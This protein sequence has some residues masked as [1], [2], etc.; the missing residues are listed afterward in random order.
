METRDVDNGF[1]PALHANHATFSM[2]TTISVLENSL[3]GSLEQWTE[4]PKNGLL[5]PDTVFQVLRRFVFEQEDAEGLLA[6][7]IQKGRELIQVRQYVGLLP[8][9][10]QTQLEILPKIGPIDQARARLLTMLR[11]LRHSP[12]RTLPDAQTQAI[13][14]PLWEVFMATFL[15]TVEP[16]VRQGIQHAYVLE[17]SNERYWKGKF[18]ATRQQRE[19]AW[20][21][22]RL[23][24]IHD[25]LTADVAANRILKTLLNYLAGETK[26]PGTLRRISQLVW[27]MDEVPISDV[28]ADDFR[29]IRR[30]GRLFRRYETALHW[31][32]AL[33]YGRGYGVKTG[34]TPNL[35]LL[36][37]MERVF[38]D[39]VTHGVRTYWPESDEVRIQ[40]SSAHLVDEHIGMPKFKLRPDVIIRHNTHTLVLD[41]KWKS[42]N[43]AEPN[44]SQR[45][46][47]YGIEQADLYQLY[48][49][50]KKYNA[51]NL[52]LIYPASETFQHPLPVFDYDATTRL[53]IWPF[54]LTNSLANEVEKLATYAFSH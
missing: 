3:I 53:H 44:R 43:A 32:E 17:E 13:S 37:P 51:D 31:A 11:Q 12:F 35:A 19:N 29:L 41:M 10:P 42:I 49:Y 22:E 48:A 23:A 34:A 18:Q 16:L 27:A 45:M 5:V 26:N 4:S 21:A 38:E 33:A 25:T 47:N 36:F 20:H 40:E 14:L 24:V 7:S 30:S 39:H 15:D 54:D 9:T 46:G 28:L 6:F 8:I 52:F 2:P 1:P 50:G